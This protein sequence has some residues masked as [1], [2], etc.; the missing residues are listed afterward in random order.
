MNIDKTNNGDFTVLP[1][2][3]WKIIFDFKDAIELEELKKRLMKNV[4]MG[5]YSMEQY[6]Q[7]IKCG[8]SIDFN[9]IVNYDNKT[10]IRQYEID[11]W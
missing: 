6:T 1:I 3:I 8:F 9:G 7:R 4:V 5:L 10:D 2:E 11:E